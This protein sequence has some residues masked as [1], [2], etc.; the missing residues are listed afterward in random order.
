MDRIAAAI[1]IAKGVQFLQSLMIP[2]VN[3]N[4]LE[5]TDILL[6][7]NLVPKISSYNLPFL[8]DNMV[9]VRRKLFFPLPV[10]LI[11]FLDKF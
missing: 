2:G 11:S 9:K 6:D 8:G 5:I 10:L 1:G 4:N 3:S 7:L